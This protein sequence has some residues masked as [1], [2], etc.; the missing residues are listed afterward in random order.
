MP[1]GG[2]LDGSLNLLAGLESLRRISA[3]GVPPVTVRLVDWA[4]EE[5]CFGHSLLGSS[6]ASGHLDPDHLLS[7]T[8]KDGRRL[9]D[10]LAEYGVE[11][12]RM[13][14]CQ[15][16]LRTAVACLELHIEQGPVLEKMGLPLGVVEGTFGVERHTVTFRG[17]AAHAGSTP[18][19]ERR[20]AFAAAARLALEVRELAKRDGGVGTTGSITLQPGIVTAI[21]GEARLSLDLRHKESAGLASMLA[22]SVESSA[23]IAR[24]ED[25]EVEW[26]PLWDIH[27][28][29]FDSELIALAEQAVREVS[30][31]STRLASGPLHD[32]ASVARAG[33]P[34]VML[35]AQSLRGLSHTKEEDTRPEHIELSVRALDRLTSL[36]LEK[37]SSS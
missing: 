11:A 13:S 15:S 24:E 31:S 9:V 34:T 35:F 37:V 12:G 18:M 21:A 6:A 3:D 17:Q 25:V 32:A 27:P 16:Q 22:A 2:W 14:L 30:G 5:G 19:A 33:I 23:T 8:G 29:P 28:I 10:A 1:N 20:D 26:E 7:L 36:T 4:D